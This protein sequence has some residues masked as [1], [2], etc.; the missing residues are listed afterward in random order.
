MAQPLTNQAT[1]PPQHTACAEQIRRAAKSLF[2]EHG[3][4]AVSIAAIASRAECSKSNIFHHF[5]NKQ[6]LYFDVM[7]HATQRSVARI[8]E[9]MADD[10]DARTRLNE[11]IK[12]HYAMLAEDPGRSR[13]MLRE[14]MF[15][16][17]QRGQE[18]ATE[19]FG[20][21]FSVLTE[22]I[23]GLD[24]DKHQAAQPGGTG[25]TPQFL[26]FMLIAANV[27][28]FHC[29]NVLQFLPGADFA[30]DTDRYAESVADVLLAGLVPRDP[31]A[32]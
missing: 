32:N 5:G 10:K 21:Q 2:A 12:A 6:S 31:G 27:M 15:S 8:R 29:H 18:L 13:L 24:N 19:V 23:R 16:N 25:N 20:E 3:F 30:N 28:L 26:A 11:T 14:V 17:P 4:E 9:I 7:R 1:Q 22:L